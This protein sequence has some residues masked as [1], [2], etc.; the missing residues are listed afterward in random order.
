MNKR[1]YQL[2]TAGDVA[3]LT[4]YG[5]ITSWP[6][7]ESDVSSYNLSK[8][9]AE[10]QGVK[11]IN[12]YLNSMGGDVSEGLAI[13]NALRRHPAHVTTYCDG[14][15]C[16]VASVIFMAGDTRIMENASLLMIHNAWMYAHGNAKEMRKMADDLDKIT[17]ASV[18]AYMEHVNLSETVLKHKMDAETWIA[19]NEA[20]EWGFAT[21]IGDNSNAMQRYSQSAR[22]RLFEML[23]KAQEAEDDEDDEETPPDEPETPM[24]P[25]EPEE[26]DTTDDDEEPE[27]K[28]DE[29]AQR[30]SGFFNALLNM[31]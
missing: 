20:V 27:E 25:A 17:A 30:W 22:N 1:Y 26:P 28:K 6:W 31:H 9:L 18:A 24:E 5:D 2:E 7:R 8:Q 15:A 19:P 4:I 3:N 23:M 16:S 11:N 12:V 21:Q 13:Y 10:M 29:P 14:M